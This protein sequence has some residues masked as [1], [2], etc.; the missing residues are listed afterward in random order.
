[1]A[2]AGPGTNGSQFFITHVATPWLNDKHTIFGHV[3]L[4]QAVVNAIA[5]N[6]TMR[7]VRIVRVG[8]MAKAFDGV[9]AFTSGEE[10]LKKKEEAA[11]K[12]ALAAWDAKVKAKYPTAKRTA[13]GLYYVI[14]QEGTGA[15]AQPGQT[16]VAHYTGTLFDDGKKFDSSVD[17]GQPFEFPIG[18]HRVIAGWDEGFALLKVGT[19]GKL[20]IPYT[21][22]YGDRGAGGVIGPKADLVF[23]VEMIGVK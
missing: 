6:D 20:I 8:K 14:D 15:L 17:R 5:T 10:N 16:V 3:V 1:M 21:L 4:G 9:K 11:N 22:A 12:A 13:S 23:E 18:Q 19:K 7:T 2:N